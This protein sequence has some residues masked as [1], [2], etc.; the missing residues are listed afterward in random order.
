[1]KVIAFL[2]LCLFAI[3]FGAGYLLG[4]SK[5]LPEPIQAPQV[6]N[7]CTLEYRPVGRKAPK[8]LQ[9]TF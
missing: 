7:V 3:V 2:H 6:G 8:P 9:F 4:V 5:R 1:M